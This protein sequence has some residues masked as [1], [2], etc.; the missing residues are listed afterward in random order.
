[1]EQTV[2]ICDDC[3]KQLANYKCEL[4]SSD[5]CEEC[6]RTIDIGNS[7]LKIIYFDSRG[8]IVTATRILIYYICPSCASIMETARFK[9]II[10][11]SMRE[12]ILQNIKSQLM[13]NNLKDGKK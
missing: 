11:E 6:Y 12:E 8:E 2:R 13:L 3:K 4:C 10:S 5:I 9:P 1:M 7:R